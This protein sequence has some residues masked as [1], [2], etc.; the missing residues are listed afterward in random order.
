MGVLGICSSVFRIQYIEPLRE[1]AGH[2]DFQNILRV[3]WISGFGLKLSDRY[4]GRPDNPSFLFL[5]ACLQRYASFCS[6][7]A[8]SDLGIRLSILHFHCKCCAHPISKNT[9]PKCNE[10]KVPACI[11]ARSVCLTRAAGDLAAGII[12]RTLFDLSQH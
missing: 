6:V 10:E 4:L 7:A 9:F 2:V 5:S 11:L 1:P 8:M 3:F 12:L